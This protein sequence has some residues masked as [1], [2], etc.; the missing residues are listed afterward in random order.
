MRLFRLFSLLLLP[1]MSA[2][3][4]T[5][6]GHLRCEYRLDP[7]GIDAPKPHLSWII[8]S[9]QVGAQQTAC[10]VLVASSLEAL[11]KDQ[12]DLW[13]S[14]K[15]PSDASINVE[16]AG[17]PLTSRQS[18]YWKV[19]VWDQAGQPTPWSAPAHW[20]M[21]L[22]NP[23][24]WQAH[25]IG[26]DE[27]SPLNGAQWIWYPEGNPLESAPPG[28][29]YF[30]RSLSLPPGRKPVAATCIITADDA[31]E[32][33]LNGRR[34]GQGGDWKQLVTL[35]AGASLHPGENLLT[36]TAT[37]VGNA[38]TPAGLILKLHVEFAQ[39]DPLDVVSDGRWEASLDQKQWTPA[40]ALGAYG[41]SPWGD[42]SEA[43]DRRLP[44][45]YLRREFEVKKNVTRATAYVCG[46]GFFDL[47]LNGK[48][49][50]DEVMDPA[51]SDYAKADYYVTFDVTRELRPGA[52]AIGA[53]LGNGRFFAPRTG[54]PISTQTFGY[55]KLLLQLEIE[56]AD[57]SRTAVVSDD[58]WRLT[59]DGPIRA[60]NEYDGEDYDARMELSGWD[61]PG[62]DETKW[63][64]VQMVSAPASVLQAQMIEP[65]RVTEVLKP[66]A[67]TNPKPGV[68]EVDFGQNFYGAVR[69][70]ARGPRDATV[71]MVCAYSLL[72][73]GTLKTADNRGARC[74]DVYTFKGRGT[75]VW[76]P[77][78][79]GQGFRH[80]EVT[81]FPGRPTVDNF[82]AR[83]IHTDVDPV[84]EFQCSNELV[85]RI[86]SAMR[87]GMRMFLRSAPLD[88]DRDERQAWMGDPAKDAESEAY[89]FN[90]APFYT[91]W[92]DDVRRSQRSDGSIPDVAMYWVMGEG[93]EWPG[94]FTIIPDWM[95]D[96]YG[97]D[98]VAKA[99]YAAMK[100]WVLAMRRH[101]LPDGTL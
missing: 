83:V 17:R 33:A 71:R 41:I 37:N 16:Y 51:L 84:G 91:K 30:R 100:S 66:V 72:P 11:A 7:L 43:E 10:Q 18:C 12:G 45:R 28:T 34:V 98:R 78:F 61:R 97:D 22:L 56:Y 94:V 82:D 15:A 64:P 85:N 70:K 38:P 44:A 55:P 46:L 75:E 5:T 24:D 2:S 9:H 3:A 81:G 23:A 59:T 39:G 19:R 8:Q 29:R 27:V 89:N 52:N 87:W 101:E 58:Q 48:K 49:I 53:I 93:V 77:E 73:E 95:A 4:L 74:T 68:F 26:R 47:F 76:S 14:G 92:M 60:N 21:G 36:V 57:G 99:N 40:K 32:L 88:P 86:H 79:K 62:Y 65:M 63:K 50:S 6:V 69:L 1:A 42:V 90:V 96:F 67:I 25:W 54:S 35:D 13:D 31:F 20:S 80:V